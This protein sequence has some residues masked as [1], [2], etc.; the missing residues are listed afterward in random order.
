MR[1]LIKVLSIVY[2]KLKL[3]TLRVRALIALNKN[4]KSEKI[5]Q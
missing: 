5:L 1:K 3:M 2:R 4:Y